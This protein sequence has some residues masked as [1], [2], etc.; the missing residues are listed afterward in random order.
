MGTGEVTDELPIAD[1][2]GIWYRWRCPSC[3]AMN[4]SENDTR[5][6]RVTCADC[7]AEAQHGG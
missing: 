3:E 6:Q 1:D 5:R 4:E 7:G 2:E